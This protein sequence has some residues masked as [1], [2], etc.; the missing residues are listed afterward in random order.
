MCITVHEILVR[1]VPSL[2]KGPREQTAHDAPNTMRMKSG[3]CY[4]KTNIPRAEDLLPNPR[5]TR[6][7]NA[8]KGHESHNPRAK[9]NE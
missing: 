3:L 4:N 8:S 7:S 6:Q 1:T 5:L 2:P 9:N